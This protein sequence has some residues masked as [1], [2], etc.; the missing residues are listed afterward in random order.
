MRAV[1]LDRDGVICKNRPDH[2]KSWEEFE[3]LPGAIDSLV[4]LAGL[5]LPIIVITNQSV[6]NRG[7][8][9]ASSIEEIHQRMVV[10][11]TAHGGRIDDV[12]Y[13]PHRPDEQCSCRKPE[14]GLLLTAARRW[15]VD[16]TQSYLV[17]DAAT[18][19]VAGQ[20]VGCRTFIV[21]TGRGSQ[22]LVPAFRLAQQP[23]TIC[24]NLAGA[25]DQILKVEARLSDAQLYSG[26]YFTASPNLPK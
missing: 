22:Q 1:F 9:T 15:N 17:G 8:A 10:E 24:R 26:N 6:I 14:P 5:E 7:M 19:I 4:T 11:I 13:C 16:L 2:V 18:D 12:L 3:F 21:L 25:T 23:F 20:Q